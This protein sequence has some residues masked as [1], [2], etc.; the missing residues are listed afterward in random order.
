MPTYETIKVVERMSNIENLKKQAK[1]ILHWHR[2]G[3]F[4]VAELIRAHLPRFRNLS[5]AEIMKAGFKLS[6]AQELI[7][8]QHGFDSWQALTTGATS[9]SN[10]VQPVTHRTLL[11]KAEPQLF[12]SDIRASCQY[13]EGVLG[14]ATAFMY[15]EPPF[16]AQVKRDSVALN[17]R[18][19]SQP[20]IDPDLAAKEDLLAVSIVV[21]DAKQ[22]FLEFQEAG[23]E[24]HE[25]LRKEPWGARTFIVKDPDR[26]LL[27]FAD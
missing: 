13:F 9:M 18:C 27:L 12:V 24:F 6:D 4:P 22:L 11:L 25:A 14:F 7:A 21:A 5:D 17:L 26:N 1:Q 16:Y 15:G 3:Y 20:A 10:Q 23:A 2:D 19:V 8:R